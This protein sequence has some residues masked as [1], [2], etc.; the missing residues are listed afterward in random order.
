MSGVVNIPANSGPFVVHRPK[1][2]RSVNQESGVP[3]ALPQGQAGCPALLWGVV[4]DAVAAELHAGTR[5][6]WVPP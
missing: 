5:P 6:G 2:T 4:K 1:S 3:P